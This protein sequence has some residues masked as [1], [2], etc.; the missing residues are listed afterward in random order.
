MSDLDAA[1]AE[2]KDYLKATDDP[3]N[4]SAGL[5]MLRLVV[6]YIESAR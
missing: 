2:A 5:V 1:L 6:A 4:W 3:R